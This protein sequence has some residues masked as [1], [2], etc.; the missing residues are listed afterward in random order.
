MTKRED[1]LSIILHHLQVDIIRQWQQ[2]LETV[3]DAVAMVT[4]RGLMSLEVGIRDTEFLLHSWGLFCRWQKD[5]GLQRTGGALSSEA[6]N[7][8][9][10]IVVLLHKLNAKLKV[11]AGNHLNLEPDGSLQHSRL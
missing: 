4:R 11:F 10:V 8:L 1:K 3:E 6:L 5:E 9:E 7:K 2:V